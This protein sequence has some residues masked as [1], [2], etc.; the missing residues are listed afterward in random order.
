MAK[1]KKMTDK[2]EIIETMKKTGFSFVEYLRNTTIHHWVFFLVGMI[3][4]G[5]IFR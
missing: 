2:K 3:I 4:G 5:I 1:E